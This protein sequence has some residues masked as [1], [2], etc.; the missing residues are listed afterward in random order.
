MINGYCEMTDWHSKRAAAVE[1]LSGRRARCRLRIGA[2]LA[3]GSD[4]ATLIEIPP[5]GAITATESRSGGRSR[6]IGG[7]NMRHI[8]SGL[9]GIVAFLGSSCFAAG[10]TPIERGKYL[11]TLGGCGDCHTPGTFLGR[12]DKER[13]LA[14]SDV[15]FAVPGLGVFPGRN[16]TPDR[17]TG[18]GNWSTQEIV[19]AITSGKRP[20]GR[21]LD[22][23]MP[24]MALSRLTP[25]DANAI[26]A[27]LKSIPAV[28]NSVPGPFG[29]DEKPSVLVFMIVPGDVYASMPKPPPK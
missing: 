17:E 24:W 2:L 6:S 21:I 18:I 23:I 5:N 12:P 27:Y 14:G 3:Q 7:L 10:E 13:L 22:P 11:V 20:D 4:E 1:V 26:A 16:L 8:Y 25:S 19:T 15:G 9:L 29:A 28:D